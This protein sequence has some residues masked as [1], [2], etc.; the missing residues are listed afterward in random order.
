MTF[1]RSRSVLHRVRRKRPTAA[2]LLALSIGCA[3]SPAAIAQGWAP[4]RNVELVV[5]ASAGGSLDITA[6]T[7]QQVVQDLK[8]V[9]APM[10]VSNRAGA[11]HLIAYSYLNQRNG[12]P[13]HI[14]IATSV[15]VTGHIEG[16]LPVTYTDFSPLALLLTEYIA[17]AVPADSPLATG[18]QLLEALK[19]NP[20]S[21]TIALG[22]APGGTHHI[23][24]GLPLQSA[25]IDVGKVTF[26]GFKSSAEAVTS[27]LGGNVHVAVVGTVNA[28]PHVASGKLRV[29]AVSAP[30]RL[31][32]ALAAVPTWPE[33]GHRGVSGSWR[34]VIASRGLSPEHVTYWE[35]VLERVVESELFR[36]A[37]E[38]NQWEVTFK[39]SAE[40][41]KYMEE[42]YAELRGVIS[43]LG[44]AKPQ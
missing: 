34:S 13:H 37:A 16:R 32:G 35:N 33:L 3:G 6:R 28:V 18:K 31:G 26:V 11:G 12:D 20:N 29:L 10:L 25:G 19:K 23:T 40:T 7:V 17:F 8:L 1:P 30:R 15:L 24:A 44:L 43:Y 27:L 38:K 4:Q 42:Q 5:P 9:R 21:L 39:R 36:T 41:R 22:S 2:L 14:A